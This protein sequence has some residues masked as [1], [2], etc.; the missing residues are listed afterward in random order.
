MA[1]REGVNPLRPYYIPPSAGLSSSSDSAPPEIASASSSQIFGSS[2]RD[3][4]PDL[5]YSDYL[6]SS[7]SVS[8]W[9]R[10]TLNRA[11]WRYT[12]TLTAQPFD[13]AKTIL[14]TY[15]VPDAEES[16]RTL[17]GQQ[18]SSPQRDDLYDEVCSYT[19]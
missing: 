8:D 17:D 14:Q 16:Q 6:E 9:I 11:L 1:S 19:G 3:L 7:P 15:V 18:G 10:D 13:V 4:F 5:D 2:P 12:S